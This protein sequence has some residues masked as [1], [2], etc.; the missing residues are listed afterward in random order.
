MVDR[1]YAPGPGEKTANLLNAL[2]VKGDANTDGSVRLRPD[3]QN[4][5]NLVIE[6]RS[7]GV[8]NPTGVEVA[9]ST[10][11]LGRDLRLGGD[12]DW[13]RQEKQGAAARDALIPHH[14]FSDAGGQPFADQ[15]GDSREVV[16]RQHAAGRVRG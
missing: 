5:T 9:A 13:L 4:P 6:E 2:Y 1:V 7:S 10:I 11:Y 16:P 12:G 14:E 15:C 3:S 8:W